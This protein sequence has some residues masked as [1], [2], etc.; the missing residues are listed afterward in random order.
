[1]VS[2]TWAGITKTGTVN[3]DHS[4]TVASFAHNELPISGTFQVA[5]DVSDAVGNPATTV[6][7]AVT[8]DPFLGGTGADVFYVP[9]G[10]AST[11]TTLTNFTRSQGDKIDLHALLNGS[12][13]T[14]V[15]ASN[16]LSLTQSGADAV[17]KIDMQG[18][19]NFAS[20]EQTFTM[21]NAWSNAGGLND[22][23]NNLILNSVILL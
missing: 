18:A 2:V 7:K 8:I 3:M 11:P 15:N 9:P 22:T 14:S 23:L 12:G 10:F 16:F 20:P 1:M 21:T 5:V 6:T 17:L 19:S 13:C 4:W